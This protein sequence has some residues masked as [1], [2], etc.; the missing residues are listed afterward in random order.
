VYD[1]EAWRANSDNGK[2]RQS[3]LILTSSNTTASLTIGAGGSN[4]TSGNPTSLTVG[5]DTFTAIGGGAGGNGSGSS[6]QN[7]EIGGSGGAGANNGGAGVNQNG[8]SAGNSFFGGSSTAVGAGSDGGDNAGGGGGGGIGGGAGGKGATTFDGGT[9][10]GEGE[11]NTGAGGGGGAA[12]NQLFARNSNNSGKSGGSGYA[13]LILNYGITAP[14]TNPLATFVG[15]Y[16]GL[17]GSASG[18]QNQYP[19]NSQQVQKK[20]LTQKLNSV[21]FSTTAMQPPTL[22]GLFS[23]FW[24]R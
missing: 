1:S 16:G 22:L 13:V 8:S 20:I 12:Y 3:T 6:G 21:Q 2:S 5:S 23:W 11:A 19:Y 7:T 10:G 18:F 9:A 14:A 15:R 24:W 4:S 17:S